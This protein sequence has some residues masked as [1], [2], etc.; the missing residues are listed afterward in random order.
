MFSYH[1]GHGR[2][3]G[4]MPVHR[5]ASGRLPLLLDPN[6]LL[7]WNADGPKRRLRCGDDQ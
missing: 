5:R 3:S 1:V 2:D 7:G 4:L 6:A